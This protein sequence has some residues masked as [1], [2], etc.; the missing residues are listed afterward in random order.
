MRSRP[1]ISVAVSC[2]NFGAFIGPCLEGLVTQQ[3][4]VPFEIVVVD[5]G[6]TDHSP[7]VIEAVR[8]RHPHLVRFLP[9]AKNRGADATKQ[10]ACGA[11]LGD[12]IAFLDGDD[13]AYPGKLEAQ[14]RYLLENPDCILCYHD[15]DL[16]DRTGRRLDRTFADKFYNQQ[17][18]PAKAGMEHLVTYGT[19]LVASS[20]MFRREA[21]QAGLLPGHIRCVGDFYYHI[22]SASLG[23][24]GRLDDCLGAY[25]KH[26]DSFCGLTRHSVERRWQALQDIL[27]ACDHAAELGLDREIVA[28]G[29]AHFRFAAALFF[30]KRG[31]HEDFGKA[32]EQSGV[33]G[34]FF[35]ARHETLFRLRHDPDR[36]LATFE[37]GATSRA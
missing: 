1:V 22:H 25:R 23:L 12:Y 28:R 29:K 21:F 31:H 27:D 26:D 4:S 16:V 9:H 36:A 2:Y 5:D 18:I 37:K 30:L 8:A 34:H 13:L 15:M 17:H 10:T 7:A 14:Y 6:S 3:C 11:C 19:F 24:L 20:Q 32:M 35:D 33:G